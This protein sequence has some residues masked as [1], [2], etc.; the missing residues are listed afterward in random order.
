MG[1]SPLEAKFIHQLTKI[2]GEVLCEVF[3]NPRKAY[4]VLNREQCL[5]I[6]TEYGVIPKMERIL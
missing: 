5:E 6:L 1:T 3:L 2:R 4:N